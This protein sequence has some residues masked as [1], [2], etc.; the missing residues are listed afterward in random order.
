[1]IVAKIME[2]QAADKC[3]HQ[4]SGIAGRVDPDT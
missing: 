4:P 1:V 3:C 2:R